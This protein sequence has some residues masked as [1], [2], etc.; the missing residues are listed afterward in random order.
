M[1]RTRQ[2]CGCQCAGQDKFVGASVQ[3]KTSLWVSVCSTS[4]VGV[5]LQDKYLWVS[6][7]RTS[8]WVSVCRTSVV[9]ASVQDMYVGVGVQEKCCG[10]QCAV[11]HG[12]L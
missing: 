6:V 12:C 9:G 1:C 7:Y 2:V 8:L 11:L 3:D 5:R 10:C 4:V